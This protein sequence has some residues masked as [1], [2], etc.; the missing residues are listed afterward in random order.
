MPK[1]DV[2]IR[3]VENPS[4]QA[5]LFAV[6]SILAEERFSN[7]L[8]KKYIRREMLMNSPLFNEWV[9]E[10]RKEAA[11][12][13]TKEA[14]KESAKKYIIELLTEKFDF[15]TKDIRETI[16]SIDD[17]EILDELLKKIIKLD[18]IEDFKNLLTKAKQI[19]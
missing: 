11:K 5:D 7:E 16:D 2:T 8:V 10:E 1:I 14:I 4:L 12:K 17:I 18:T 3:T 13:A 15:V 19:S 6:M 9:E